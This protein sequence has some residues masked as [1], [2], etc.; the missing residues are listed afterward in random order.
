MYNELNQDQKIKFNKSLQS[1]LTG[2][3]KV[4]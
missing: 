4:I 1:T 2:I 3:S